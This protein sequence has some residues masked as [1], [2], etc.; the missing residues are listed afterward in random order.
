VDGNGALRPGI[1]R[2]GLHPNADGYKLMAPVA[3][4]AVAKALQ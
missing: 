4:A 3:A 2:D 1:S